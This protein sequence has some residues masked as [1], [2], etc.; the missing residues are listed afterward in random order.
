MVTEQPGPKLEKRHVLY[1]LALL[2][3]S[4]CLGTNSGTSE[5]DT[6][7][8]DSDEDDAAGESKDDEDG[9]LEIHLHLVDDE[10]ETGD[11]LSP[12]EDPLRDTAL[13]K[14]IREELK[15]TPPDEWPGSSETLVA[16]SLDSDLAD[17]IQTTLDSLPKT[18]EGVP[19]RP[20][21]PCIAFEE[22]T[23]AITSS[24]SYND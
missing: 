15:E 10:P 19:R 14:L 11:C 6:D 7:T 18:Y 13:L 9:M 4:G 3:V 24:V 16:G 5:N 17:S 8:T 1:S 23:I 12:D 21:A 22:Y 20:A 2:P